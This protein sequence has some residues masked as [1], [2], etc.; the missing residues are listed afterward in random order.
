MI[1]LSPWLA[2]A[3][4]RDWGPARRPGA[5]ADG[6]DGVRCNLKRAAGEVKRNRQITG[7]CA[8]FPTLLLHAP[9]WLLQ[10]RRFDFIFSALCGDL[11]ASALIIV[12]WTPATGHFELTSLAARIKYPPRSNW[13]EGWFVIAWSWRGKHSHS[14]EGVA[15]RGSQ[16]FILCPLEAES[17]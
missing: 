8:C 9:H 13:W 12:Y 2:A 10:T 11:P 1:N 6:V 5:K 17:K 3:S 7:F 16:V 15:R 14:K 4:L